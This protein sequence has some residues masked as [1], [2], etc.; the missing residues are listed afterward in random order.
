LEANRNLFS[1]NGIRAVIFDLDGTLRHNRPSF[2]QACCDYAIQ[3]G[4][5]D[6]R[7]NRQ[8]AHRWLHY[9]WAQSPEL[10]ADLEKFG[11][12]KDD[13]WENHARLYLGAFGCSAEQASEFAPALF[14]CMSEDYKPQDWVPE[15]VP[16]T[17]Q[18]LKEAGFL[19]AVASNRTETYQEQLENLGLTDFFEFA[20]A[21]GEVNSWKPDPGIFQ[22]AIRR[23]GTEPEQTLYVGDNYF[24]DVIGA[25]NANLRPVLIDPENI[26]PEAQCKVIHRMGDLIEFLEE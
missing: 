1:P 25:S 15:E 5:T 23:L 13:F 18:A 26:F 20:L 19:L 22:H 4:L 10:M 3:L 12:R 24:A 14:R 9:Y 7:E 11:E 2:N 21:A 8:S 17:L 6:G 16:E